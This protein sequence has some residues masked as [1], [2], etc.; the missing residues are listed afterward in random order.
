MLEI[1]S[2]KPLQYT[3]ECNQAR[4]FPNLVRPQL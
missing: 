2:F 1:H 3:C 4:D